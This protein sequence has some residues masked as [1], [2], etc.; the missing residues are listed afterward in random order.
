MKKQFIKFLS[1][2][3]AI[4]SCI[5][6]A[7]QIAMA[8]TSANIITVRTAEESSDLVN[9]HKEK[10]K[11]K[12]DHKHGDG[13]FSEENLKYLSTEQ[14]KQLKELKECIDSGKKLSEEQ[15]KILHSLI[16]CIIKGKLGEEK[17]KDFKCLMEKKKSGSELTEAESKKLKEYKKIIHG[18]KDCSRTNEILKQF[19]R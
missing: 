3:L 6:T 7:P 18:S 15:E 12:D 17:Y 19:L 5:A 2:S 10:D 4:I 9:E 13:I 14:K 8:E 11:A 16:D 1:A